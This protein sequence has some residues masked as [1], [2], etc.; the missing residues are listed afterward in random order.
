MDDL[1]RLKQKIEQERI[2]LDILTDNLFKHLDDTLDLIK[3][4]AETAAKYPK[5][6]FKPKRLFIGEDGT[7]QSEEI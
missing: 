3:D 7:I 1:E 6:P 2:E 5:V 4:M